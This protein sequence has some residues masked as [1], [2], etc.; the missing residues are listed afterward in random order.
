MCNVLQVL[1]AMFVITPC[2]TVT[3]HYAQH[4]SITVNNTRNIINNNTNNNTN[5]NNNNNNN[6]S[7]AVNS[8]LHT[9]IRHARRPC[10]SVNSRFSIR[11]LSVTHLFTKCQTPASPS[12]WRTFCGCYDAGVCSLS[13][14]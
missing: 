1:S 13:S 10:C 14:L 4:N 11:S 2:S 6:N 8:V 9:S 7:R 12:V 3:L 5:N